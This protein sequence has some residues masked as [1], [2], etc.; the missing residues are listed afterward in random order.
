MTAWIE[1]TVRGGGYEMLAA[2]L[3]LEN[4]SPPIPSEVILPL[5]GA[6]VARGTLSFGP[7]VLAATAGSVAGALALYALGRFGGRRLLLRHGRLL[8]LDESRLD[9]ADRWFDRHAGWI[10]L[11][12]RLVPGVRSVVSVPAGAAQMP[13]GSFVALTS[14]GSA[15]WNAAL[16]GAAWA[17]AGQWRQ[18]TRIVEQATAVTL[19]VVMAA[20]GL[21]IAVVI[22]RRRGRSAG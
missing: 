1:D 2:L 15:I 18:V 22:R 10:V 8:R 11:A 20:A 14:V 13:L 7:A 16:I 19:A 9:H 21:A 6:A 3:A 4:L 5:A 12:G 17:L